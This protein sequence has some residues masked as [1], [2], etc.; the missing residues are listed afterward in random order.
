MAA[1]LYQYSG[2]HPAADQRMIGWLVNDQLEIVVGF[3]GFMGK[4][5]QIHIAMRPEFHFS[6]KRMLEETFRYAFNDC[7]RELLIGI[8][9][10]ENEKA[11][12]YDEHLGFKELYRIPQ[13]HDNGGDIVVLGMKKSE[14]RY[15]KRQVNGAEL[16]KR[17]A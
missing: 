3:S 14:C 8:V 9:N 16:L 13:M 7:E 6:P 12:K 1:F 17:S 10:S 11:M 2:V 15:L 5:C 4:V